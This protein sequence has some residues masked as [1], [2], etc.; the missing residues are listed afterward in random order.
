MPYVLSARREEEV[1]GFVAQFDQSIAVIERGASNEPTSNL[2]AG[3]LS[4]LGEGV[5]PFE[6]PTIQG[7]A[8]LDDLKDDRA[9][10]D[11]H[12]PDCPDRRRD[13]PPGHRVVGEELGSH[14]SQQNHIDGSGAVD[15]AQPSENS[16]A[17][18]RPG[19]L[20]MGSLLSR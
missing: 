11:Y 18:V 1:L 9:E 15:R 16:L 10:S 4:F 3:S 8:A 5:R 7:L 13:V 6:S 12:G 14:H 17:D 20:G 19:S 2:S